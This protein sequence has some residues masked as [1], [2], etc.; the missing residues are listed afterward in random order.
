[1]ID[2]IEKLLKFGCLG[3]YDQVEITEIFACL[4]DKSIINVFTIVVA[5][6]R[7]EANLIGLSKVSKERI[8]LNILKDWSFGICRYTKSISDIL[9]DFMGLNAD[10]KWLA[11]GKELI[12]GKME[13]QAQ[14]FVTS[15]E[16]T[17]INNIIKNNFLNGSYIVEWF[18]KDKS[19]FKPFLEKP[20]LLQELSEKI[21]TSCPIALASISDRLGNILFQI[22]IT[23]LM[24]KFGYSRQEN[25]FQLKI[26][27][28]PKAK[29]RALRLN[30]EMEYDKIINGYHSCEIKED[31]T[32]IP[33]SHDYGLHKGIVWDDENKLIIAATLPNTF[34]RSVQF[35]MGVME[36][37]PRVFKA[38]GQEIRV[39]VVHKQKN[40]LI[41][42]PSSKVEN[43]IQERLYK[44]EKG[45]LRKSRK[46]VQYKPESNKNMHEQAL[47]DI[48]A[49]IQQYGENSVW[50]WDPFLSA[51]DIINTLFYCSF[52]GAKLRAITNLDTHPESESHG[53]KDQ[54]KTQKE[55]F[56]NLD[57]N[58]YGINLEF[59]A[60]IGNAG[61]EFHDRFL[62]FPD[63]QQGA[64]AWSLG[65][66]VNSLGKKH[67]ILQ[68]VDDGQ[69]IADAFMELW[70]QLDK[71]DNLLWK[72]P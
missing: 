3:F 9:T 2:E 12:I 55:I 66:S 63:T 39:E 41:G 43:W 47:A 26:A 4:P 5:E 40:N 6:D 23:I 25:N 52:I 44:D 69:L 17:P 34:I 19:Y 20:S 7:S 56:N 37:E 64:L 71:P 58:F 14:K 22:P 11:S 57:S 36:H 10:N 29:Q 38:D 60:R 42:S 65:T 68:Q 67:H 35:G 8:K 16:R 72:H 32:I 49:L 28:H 33:M 31:I 53:K 1:M 51:N 61:W 48:R 54:L 15:D 18:D 70:N 13:Y 59:R 30:C 27:W 21:Q 50:L 62:I 45:R 46:F 24:A